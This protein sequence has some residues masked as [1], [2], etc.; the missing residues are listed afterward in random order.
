MDEWGVV[1]DWRC[2]LWVF[3]LCLLLKLPF[4]FDLSAGFVYSFTVSFVLLLLG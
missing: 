3:M 4:C 2:G 1:F